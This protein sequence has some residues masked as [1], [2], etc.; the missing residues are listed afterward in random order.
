MTVII[1]TENYKMKLVIKSLNGRYS[2]KNRH[3]KILKK[4]LSAIIKNK[5]IRK[6]T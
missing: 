5:L 1:L 4:E 3:G 6:R 2:K